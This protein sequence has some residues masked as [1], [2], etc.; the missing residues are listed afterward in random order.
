MKVKTT[1]FSSHIN[2]IRKA[3]NDYC[4]HFAW[5]HKPKIRSHQE[6]AQSPA[7]AFTPHSHGRGRQGCYKHQFT[8]RENKSQRSKGQSFS[9][10]LKLQKTSFKVIQM[11]YLS[12]LE[13]RSLTR[14]PQGCIPSGPSEGSRWETIPLPF[15]TSRGSLQSLAPFFH[16]QSQQ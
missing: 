14:C 15:Q 6:W 1:P 10:L 11:Y 4:P 3:R 9:C 7:Q 5:D 8:K 13:V 2:S 16:L 12:V